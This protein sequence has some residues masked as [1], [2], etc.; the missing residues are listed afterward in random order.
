MSAEGLN[1]V[2]SE[3]QHDRL[4]DLIYPCITKAEVM[5]AAYEISQNLVN[6]GILHDA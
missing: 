2:S 3:R 6:L 1:R 5:I 4:Q